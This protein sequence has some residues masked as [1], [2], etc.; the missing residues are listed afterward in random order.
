MITRIPKVVVEFCVREVFQS[1]RLTS[2][3]SS[4]NFSDCDPVSSMSQAKHLNVT[5][6]RKIVE[7][8]YCFCY[9]TS[10]AGVADL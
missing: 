7:G 8:V 2:P 3:M 9:Q 10:T 4:E 6:M 1:N 5:C